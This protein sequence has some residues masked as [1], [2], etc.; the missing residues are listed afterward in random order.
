MALTL[1]HASAGFENLERATAAVAGLSTEQLLSQAI[2]EAEVSG[3][4][5]LSTCNRLEAYLEVAPTRSRT[6]ADRLISAL[7]RRANAPGLPAGVVVHA[8]DDAIR[9]L[10]AVTAGLDSLVQGE[11]EIAGQVARAYDGARR[12]GM[13]TP[14]LD[15]VFQRALATSRTVRSK[16]RGQG[17]AE[18]S[19]AHL[20]LDL[21]GSRLE[22]WRTARV[23]LIGTG[24]HAR[25]TVRAL[26]AHHAQTVR[27]FSGTGRAREFAS[28]HGLA[29][30]PVTED[31]VDAIGQAD[32]VIACTSRVAVGL[33]DVSARRGHPLLVIDL[34]LPR[35]VDPAIGRLAGVDVLDLAG[36]A[37]HV[38][39][40]G[41][42]AQAPGMNL[43]S[44]AVDRFAAEDLA[45][46]P[47][48]AL[49]RHVNEVLEREI[50]RAGHRAPT[51]AEAARTE[52]ALRHF[53]GVLLH[54]PSMRAHAAAAEGDIEH[55]AAALGTVFGIAP[56]ATQ[57]PRPPASQDC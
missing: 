22:D 25:T 24:A 37:H 26:K 6:A 23:L 3:A 48:V 51:D 10:F 33:L 39:L 2:G 50:Q 46:A 27:V 44:D 54:T 32:L 28:R 35:N 18:V 1:T 34:G 19:V 21:A 52:A 41:L 29:P 47:V 15:A 38:N 56:D 11:D 49:R 36:I 43:V 55:F 5:V 16:V 14:T 4:V 42:G 13:T 45:A 8:D 9:H 20:A 31:L 57:A 30:V 17:G 7:S 40:P 12:L 53:A